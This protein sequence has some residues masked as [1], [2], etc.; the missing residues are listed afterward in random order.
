MW[1]ENMAKSEIPNNLRPQKFFLRGRNEGERFRVFRRKRQTFYRSST[2][3]RRFN[4]FTHRNHENFTDT[5]QEFCKIFIINSLIDLQT[6]TT[7]TNFSHVLWF[8]SSRLIFLIRF[9]FFSFNLSK[10]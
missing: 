5:L 7:Y 9:V 4:I 2:F 1:E 3:F 8:L 10:A 6:M